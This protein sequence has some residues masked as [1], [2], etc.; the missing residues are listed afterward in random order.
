MTKVKIADKN[1]I[2]QGFSRLLTVITVLNYNI[3]F[4]S[5]LVWKMQVLKTW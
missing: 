1:I 3:K 5:F 4:L 2:L